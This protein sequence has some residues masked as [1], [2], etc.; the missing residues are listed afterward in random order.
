[1]GTTIAE[2]AT[3]WKMLNLPKEVPEIIK[4]TKADIVTLQQQQMYEGRDAENEAI[5]PQYAPKTIFIKTQK[6]K[7]PQPV[8]RVTL[9]DTGA[10]YKGMRVTNIT[11]KSFFIDSR[12][13]K[14]QKLE[15]K[16]GKSIFGLNLPSRIGY[17][18][19]YFFP[20]LKEYIESVTKLKMK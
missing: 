9:K 17:V 1:M 8:D 15:D 4:Q 12:D 14:D 11:K 2:M 3:R 19:E 18:N 5:M 16:Y 10:F 7:P 6:R 20:L 13:R